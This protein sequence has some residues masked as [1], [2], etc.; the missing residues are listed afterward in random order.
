ML[1]GVLVYMGIGVTFSFLYMLHDR[2]PAARI[3]SFIVAAL[4]AYF[5]ACIYSLYAMLKS[6]H[7][8]N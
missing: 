6:E 1:I 2:A 4:H 8:G 7:F 3:G 5:F